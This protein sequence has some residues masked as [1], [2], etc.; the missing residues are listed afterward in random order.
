MVSQ[1]SQAVQYPHNTVGTLTNS[2]LP[3]ERRDILTRL[4]TYLF[5]GCPFSTSQQSLLLEFPDALMFTRLSCL[6][7]LTDN[8]SI[9]SLYQ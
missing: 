9:V 2:I 1:F 5:G 3:T 6:Y 4:V 8:F 7:L